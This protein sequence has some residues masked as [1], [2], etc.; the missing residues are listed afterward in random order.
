MQ[1]KWIELNGF[2]SFPDKTKIDINEGITCFVGPNGAG[3][4]NIVDAFRWILGEHN[5]RT[6]RGEKMEEII[7]QGSDSKKEKGLAEVSMLLTIEEK[8]NNGNEPQFREIEIKRRFYRSGESYFVINGKTSRLKNI[9]EIFLTEGVD[10]RTYAIID[11]TKI[12]E[13]LSKASHRKALLEECAG[14]SLY[15]MKRTESELKLDA[16]KENLQRIEDILS[17]LKNQY[18]LL[19]RQAKRAE[20]YKKILSEMTDLELKFAKSQSLSLLEE[21]ENL[22]NELEALENKYQDLKNRNVIITQKIEEQ[23]NKIIEI[24]NYTRKIEAKN[25]QKDLEIAKVEKELALFCQ[26]EKN[27]EER[28]EKL[29]EENAMLSDEIE[30]VKAEM[31]KNYNLTKEMEK[32]LVD[33][34]KEILLYEENLLEFHR[35]LAT[36]EKSLENERKAL[37]NLTTELANKRNLYNSLIKSFENNQNRL[38]SLRYRKEEIKHKIE[39]MEIENEKEERLIKDLHESL[40]SQNNN[41]K[42]LQNQV[43]LLEKNLEED[44]NKLIEKKKE[45]ATIKGK[46][47]ALT[48]A[49]GSEEGEGKVFFKCIDVSSEVEDLVEI[50]L[51]EKLKATVI[52]NMEVIKPSEKRRYF[53]LKTLT[54]KQK[55]NIPPDLQSLKNFIKLRE[56]NLNIDIFENIVIVEDLKEAMEK[57]E[58]LP[59]FTFITKKGEVLYPDGFIKTG[60]GEDLLKKKRILQ[61]LQ[62]QKEKISSEIDSLEK[63]LLRLRS[64]EEKLKEAIEKGENLINKLNREIFIREE[65]Q[66]NS[67]KEIETLRQKLSFM[68]KEE[69]AIREEIEKEKKNIDNLKIQINDLSI[70]IEETEEKI[71]KLKEERL[72]IL[73][74]IEDK[75]EIL[76]AKKIELSALKE[77]LNNKNTEILRIQENLRKNSLKK[78][79]NDEEI[80]KTL[81][82]LEELK[83]LQTDKRNIIQ[84]LQEDIENLNRQQNQYMEILSQ[85]KER[86]LQLEK[87]YYGLNEDLRNITTLI[88]EKNV[89]KREA[90]IKLETLW[91]EIYNLYRKDILKEEID[92]VDDDSFAKDK[93]EAL[94]TQLKNLGPVD[95]EILKEY[96]EVKRRYDFMLDQQRDIKT[97]I[98]ELEEAI[99]KI[100]TLTRKKLK[101]TFEFLKEKFNSLFQELFGGGKAVISLTKEDNIL[102]SELE[103]NVQPPGKKMSS[104]NLLSGGEKALTAIA[105]IFACLAIRPSPICILDE[106]DAPLDDINTIRLRNLIK[107]M[108]HKTQFLIITHNKLMME[109]ADYIYGVTMKEEG[110]SSIIS[111]ELKEAENY[112]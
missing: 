10:L 104:I 103:I 9:K 90:H 34:Q 56:E 8:P 1:I 110:V 31:R 11:Q 25:K 35:K 27:K 51:D 75:K 42:N 38:I 5:P 52:E 6:L 30:K 111:L 3:K 74:E 82:K 68:E 97:S 24:D 107:K 84:V 18:S 58:K 48:S 50:F 20:R 65:K 55:K 60:K 19:E 95:I 49:I 92:P 29:K 71:E 41:L 2:K 85:E 99:R 73:K 53:F 79:Q 64:E 61:N 44:N 59:D 69:R 14:I 89:Q 72:N 102:E 47:E 78:R 83:K 88:G 43:L 93:I 63:K 106:V 17:E 13:L 16:A 94:K 67:Q 22:K 112:V 37:F 26:E 36:L 7:F 28:V 86:L 91:N 32:F 101:E 100:N 4:S 87:E 62:N 66:K 40:Q 105:F 109:A 96:E 12:S 15:K 21:L 98:E 46:I 81:Y 108:I 77:R 23:K 80:K 70:Q 33:L 54:L 76:S 57:R 39:S 45:E